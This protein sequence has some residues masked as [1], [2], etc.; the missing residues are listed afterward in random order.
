MVFKIIPTNFFKTIFPYRHG[1]RSDI[2]DANR[3]SV[4]HK[5]ACTDDKAYLQAV[6]A[7]MVEE[8]KSKGKGKRK[9]SRRDDSDVGEPED[10]GLNE[11]V[12]DVVIDMSASLIDRLIGYLFIRSL[13]GVW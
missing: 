9:K 6:L 10:H 3:K 12:R 4:I 11:Q 13:A 8:K 7:S 5:A 1:A 2:P